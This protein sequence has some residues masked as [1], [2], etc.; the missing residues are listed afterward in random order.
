MATFWERAAHS[1][2]NNILFVF[3]LFVILVISRF[4][5]DGGI[6][7][8]IAPVPG[9]CIFATFTY[10]S[11]IKTALQKTKLSLEIES[12]TLKLS[13]QVQVFMDLITTSQLIVTRH[14][15]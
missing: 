11:M 8:L 4:G 15:F 6:R 9:H 10:S 5:F 7:V 1:V 3:K 2:G 12:R 13:L 14:C